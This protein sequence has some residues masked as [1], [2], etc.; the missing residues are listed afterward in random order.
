MPARRG[1][2]RALL[3]SYLVFLHCVSTGTGQSLV[4]LNNSLSLFYFFSSFFFQV[5]NNPEVEESKGIVFS[6]MVCP[7]GGVPCGGKML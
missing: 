3:F 2:P 1:H 6:D 7:T 5:M 4:G